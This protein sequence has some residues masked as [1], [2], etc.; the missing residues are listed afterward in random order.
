MTAVSAIVRQ[1]AHYAH[2]VG[3]IILLAKHIKG[4]DWKWLTIR[5]GQSEQFT[6]QLRDK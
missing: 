5:P 1:V 6:R 2:H 4:H 3:H